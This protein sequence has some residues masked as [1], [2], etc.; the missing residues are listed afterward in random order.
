MTWNHDKSQLYHMQVMA[1]V[2]TTNNTLSRRTDQDQAELQSLDCMG[3][4]NGKDGSIYP[5]KANIDNMGQQVTN[6][7]SS[8][9]QYCGRINSLNKADYITTAWTVNTAK[10]TS[11]T[12]LAPCDL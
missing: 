9:G 12:N 1:Q 4:Y 8:P 3:R 5:T 10:E 2:T 6:Q 7:V 11:G